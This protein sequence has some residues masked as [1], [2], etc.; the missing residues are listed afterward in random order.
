MADEV[1]GT[2]LYIRMCIAVHC[3]DGDTIAENIAEYTEVSI[4]KHL[5]KCYNKNQ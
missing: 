5:G 1:R 3:V 4:E 2:S